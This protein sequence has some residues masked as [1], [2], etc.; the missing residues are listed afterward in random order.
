MSRLAS[1]SWL[2]VILHT[3]TRAPRF[4]HALP[5]FCLTRF[6]Q[7]ACLLCAVLLCASRVWAL[8]APELALIVNT[9]DPASVE[10]AAYYRLKRDIPAANVIEVAF[11]HE[12]GAMPREEFER[13]YAEVQKKL[14][15]GIQA[16]AL[17]WTRPWRAAC[18]GMTAAFAFGYD[19]AFCSATCGPTR[20]SRYFNGGQG[21]AP[22]LPLPRPAMMLAGE[23]SQEVRRLIDRGVAADYSYPKGTVYLVRTEDAARNVRAV[24]FEDSKSRIPGLRFDIVPV[25][26][27]AQ[28]DDVAGY[29]TGS[30]N[31]PAIPTLGFL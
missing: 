12:V 26:R 19:E 24:L 25:A 6:L 1:V 15:P 20:A 18:M 5:M 21:V 13:V 23:S 11:A 2:R 7:A 16:F 9:A 14:P 4:Y 10:T 8:N 27:A 30:V 29:F 31:V 3:L 28:R 22:Y 17:A